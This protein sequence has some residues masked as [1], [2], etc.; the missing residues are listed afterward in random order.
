MRL[1]PVR[2]CLL[3]NGTVTCMHVHKYART[4]THI[5]A[6]AHTCTCTLSELLN[7][8]QKYARQKT[9]TS[10]TASFWSN[11]KCVHT[12]THRVA[13]M[14]YLTAHFAPVAG[15]V[16]YKASHGSQLCHRDIFYLSFLM[17]HWYKH[18]PWQSR[19]RKNNKI[20]WYKMELQTATHKLRC[21][22]VSPR[23]LTYH[24]GAFVQAGK[25]NACK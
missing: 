24:P 6:Y 9:C 1:K 13:Y 4:Y 3:K 15:L 21:R 14:R 5:D 12:D 7:I 8:D 18:F 25:S 19:P 23:K 2:A 11:M 20:N 16:K 17:I 22:L 10:L